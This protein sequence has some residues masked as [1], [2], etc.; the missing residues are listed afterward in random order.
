MKTIKTIGMTRREALKQG[1]AATAA[2]GGLLGAG[3]VA[4]AD[5]LADIKSRG[6]LVVATEMQFP[7]FDISDNGTYKGVDR[8]L[9]DAV[10][11]ELGVKV[12]YLDLPWTS[13]LPGLEEDFA[14][15]DFS[16]LLGW[17]RTEVHAQG[18]RHDLLALVQQV[19]GEAL[20]PQ[21][22]LRYLKERYGALYLK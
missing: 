18:R 20:S 9:I 11:K 21:P 10:A 4:W 19:T 22:L 2:A 3:G 17:L 7:P 13:V 16:R 6:E 1:L 5:T 14:R 15:G 8:E 12:S